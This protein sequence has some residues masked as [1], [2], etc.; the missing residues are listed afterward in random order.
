MNLEMEVGGGM[1]VQK[2]CAIFSGLFFPILGTSWSIYGQFCAI[3]ES[4]QCQIVVPILTT[5][6]PIPRNG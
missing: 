3:R 6:N 2:L 4:I 1:A 5:E